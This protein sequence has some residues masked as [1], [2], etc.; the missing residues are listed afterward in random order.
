ML[1]RETIL[2]T[3]F[4]YRTREEYEKVVKF[5]QELNEEKRT[6]H[7]PNKWPIVRVHSRYI[8]TN[9]VSTNQIPKSVPGK[10]KYIG[11][12]TGNNYVLKKHGVYPDRFLQFLGIELVTNDTNT[13]K[14]DGEKTTYPATL[15]THNEFKTV[16]SVFNKRFGH[17]NWRIQGPKQLQDIL[18]KIEPTQAAAGQFVMLFDDTL[19]T[20]YK[21]KYPGG[22]PVTFIANEA[23]ADIAKLLF[24][25]VL[26]G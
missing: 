18:R 19:V 8:S 9:A 26:K 23:N 10:K 13:Q 21:D 7:S 24:K 2:K 16:T 12:I 15:R 11:V 22:V 17:G 4:Y 6:T 25:V 14:Y 3:A 20:K 5:V 1:Q